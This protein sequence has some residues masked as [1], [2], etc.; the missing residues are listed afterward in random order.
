MNKIIQIYPWIDNKELKEVTKV[1][2]STFLT[3]NKYTKKFEKKFKSITKAKYTIAVSNW[4]M[5]LFCCL[6]ALKIG[7]NDE[8]IVPDITFIAS[9]NAVILAGAKVVLCNVDSET[10]NISTSDIE[11]MITKRTK[12]IMPVHLYGNSCNM[13][14][15]L[16]I[17]K[18]YK[19]KIIEDAAQGLGVFHKKKHVGTIG[20]VGGFSFYGNKLITT[21]E[22][23]IITTNNKKIYDEIQQLKNHGRKVKGK[24]IHEK[25][26]Y[27][28]MFTDIQAAIGLAQISK[29]KKII[30]KKLAIY[31]YYKSNIKKNE[32]IKYIKELDKTSSVYWFTNI[33]TK[34]ALKLKKFLLKKNIESRNC[35][36]P[37][38][39]QPCYDNNSD[40]IKKY[41]NKKNSLNIYK[42][43]L[44]LPSA[45]QINKSELNKVIKNI[46][47]FYEKKNK[48]TSKFS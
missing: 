11:K 5:G 38:S 20:D 9:A 29:L 18:K 7:K 31:K 46:N 40:I 10:L 34:Q 8:V 3:E 19:L 14:K 43:L 30:N 2:K 25:I 12:A 35:F 42:S 22:G 24:F 45:T 27:N 13:T 16:Q 26:G 21:G 41:V 47:S 17:A 36:Y 1:I 37:L 28:F 48:T 32:E 44:S 4:T 23:G 15:L 33:I 6:K 39:L